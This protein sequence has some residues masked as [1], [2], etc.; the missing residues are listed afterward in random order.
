MEYNHTKQTS[1]T[2]PEVKMAMES[3]DTNKIRVQYERHPN[4]FVRYKKDKKYIKPVRFLSY[5]NGVPQSA[6]KISSP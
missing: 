5:V 3:I 2:R 1:V 4:V 6:A